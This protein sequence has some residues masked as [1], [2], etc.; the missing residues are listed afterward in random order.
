MGENILFVVFTLQC[1]NIARLY[2][3]ALTTARPVLS[4]VLPDGGAQSGHATQPNA[5]GNEG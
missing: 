3:N 1:G 2:V 5:F 4:A